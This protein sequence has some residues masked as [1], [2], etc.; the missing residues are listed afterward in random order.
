MS[1]IFG[2][3][4]SM[5]EPPKFIEPK[6]EAVPNFEDIKRR[7]AEQLALRESIAKRKGRRSTILTGTGLTTNPDIDTKTL[8]GA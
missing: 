5:P 7:D 4:P 2:K 8:L 3:T 6:V 1:F